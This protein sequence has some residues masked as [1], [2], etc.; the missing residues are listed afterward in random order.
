M[1]LTQLLEGVELISHCQLLK[2]LVDW[3][4]HFVHSIL[5]FINPILYFTFQ[6]LS[7]L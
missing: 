6:V 3:L 5:H 7:F 1:V 2:R 4:H